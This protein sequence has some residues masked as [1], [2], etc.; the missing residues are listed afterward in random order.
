LKLVTV[1]TVCL[2]ELFSGV[3]IIVRNFLKLVKV[4]IVC[5]SETCSWFIFI[6][7]NG[8]RIKLI[9]GLYLFLEMI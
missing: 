4:I 5:V 3:I 9:T 6:V 7:R 8:L 1:I 2:G